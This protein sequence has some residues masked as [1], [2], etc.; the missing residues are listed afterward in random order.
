MRSILHSSCSL[1]SKSTVAIVAIVAIVKIIV[2]AVLVAPVLEIKMIVVV[3]VVVVA[4]VV[5]V[6]VGGGGGVVRMT[7]GSHKNLGLL[8]FRREPARRRGSDI[9]FLP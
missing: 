2:I 1:F 8:R 3:V 5:V 4:V 6:V 7:W 9:S